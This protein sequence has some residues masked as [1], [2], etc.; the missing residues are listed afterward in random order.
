MMATGWCDCQKPHVATH[1]LDDSAFCHPRTWRGAW[2]KLLARKRVP[3]L[4]RKMLP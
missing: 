4:L 3:I 1:P 2:R